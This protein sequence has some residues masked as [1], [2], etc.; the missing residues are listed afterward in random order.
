MKCKRLFLFFMIQR[1][2]I[3]LAM[4][5]FWGYFASG[6]LG[7]AA[8]SCD[9]LLKG[10]VIH[11]GDGS[12]PIEGDIAITKGRIVSVGKDLMFTAAM[13]IDCKG[14]VVSPGFIDLHTHSD[15]PILERD[16]RGNVNYLMQGCTTIV[17]GNCGM[18]H[19]A[20]GKYLDQV[21][22]TG[23]GT[24]VAHLLPHGSLRTQVMGKE[25]RA[26]TTEELSKMQDLAQRAMEDGAFG[27]ATGLIYIPG[28][29]AKTN[30]LIAIAEVVAKHD[31]LY[32]SHI[33]GEGRTLLQSVEEAI[34]IGTE[35]KLPTHISH[36][37]ASGKESWGSL[38][39]AVKMIE[40][41]RMEG[42]KITADQ[43]PY[44]ASSTSLEATLLPRWSRAGG[45]SELKNRL[46]DPVTAERIRKEVAE[47]LKTSSRIQIASHDAR[48][49]WI[50][51][52][53]DEIATSESM[54]MVDVVMA[55]ERNGGASVVNFGMFEDDVR[56]AMKLPWV[57]TASDGSSKVASANV[58]HPRSFGTFPRKIGF[59]AI[60][61]QVL[62]LEAA[63]RSA[64]SLP[65][66][67]LGI[68]DRGQIREG[69][70]ADIAVF[71]PDHFRDQATFE[72][73]YLPTKGLKHVLIHGEFAVY[74]G[75][76]SGALL[77]KSI[78]KKVEPR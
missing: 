8:D 53:L 59:Y 52:S 24:N 71:D 63:I 46:A 16:T 37:K 38:H 30:E 56:L 27:M 6:L 40:Q 12:K 47:E 43:Y 35:A 70:V 28:N 13:I 77:G 22:A 2:P 48:P 26:P 3:A 23:A 44:M 51:K 61:E 55:V 15:D 36:F 34:R 1:I 74:E 18:G 64:T 67:I 14:L 57:A 60:A 4:S 31:G 69:L 33:R 19:V 11:A 25:D 5:F 68:K 73:P 9:L 32:V 20:V 62:P 39:M 65:A 21:D 66:E 72:S 58:P 29:F 54:E 49:E 17:T 78:R 45:R 7:K 76:P 41:A 10:G 75:V 50:G 42:K